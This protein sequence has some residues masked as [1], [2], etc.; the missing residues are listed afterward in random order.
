MVVLAM[1]RCGRSN[2]APKCKYPRVCTNVQIYTFMHLSNRETT[3]CQCWRIRETWWRCEDIQGCFG[4]IPLF[5]E[6]RDALQLGNGAT[7]GNI[8]NG[9]EYNRYWEYLHARPVSNFLSTGADLLFHAT[10]LWSVWIIVL[11]IEHQWPL[12][13]CLLSPNGLVLHYP[14][15][16]AVSLVYYL[17]CLSHPQSIW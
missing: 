17:L 14:P 10:Y 1:G 8:L 16:L 6:A 12:S 15:L 9:R 7:F 11:S 3:R 4:Y 13:Q 2:G 5:S